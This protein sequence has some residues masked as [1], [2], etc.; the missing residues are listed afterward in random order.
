MKNLGRR[1]ELGSLIVGELRATFNRCTPAGPLP[2][3]NELALWAGRLAGIVLDEVPLEAN[4]RLDAEDVVQEA[5]ARVL[6]RWREHEEAGLDD[7]FH[8]LAAEFRGV[9]RDARRRHVD[10]KKRSVRHECGLEISDQIPDEA[11]N[12]NGLDPERV[13]WAIGQANLGEIAW[14]VVQER[15]F[16]GKPFSAIARALQ[17]S[18]STAKRKWHKARARLR[19]LLKDDVAGLDEFRGGGQASR[20]T[21]PR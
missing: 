13:N 8:W 2:P 15:L 5:F 19:R 12:S 7:R 3:E 11:L 17:I 18:V 4:A 14:R 9:A 20:P 1:G 16:E 10:S 6:A 21:E